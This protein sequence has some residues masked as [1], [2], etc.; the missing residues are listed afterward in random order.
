MRW[1]S[2]SLRTTLILGAAIAILLPALVVGY[3]QIG[4][5]FK[6]EVERRARTPTQQYAEVLS[7][8]LS[9]VMWNM[10]RDAITEQVDAVMRDPDVVSV[11]VSTQFGS[12]AVHRER[13][14]SS[15]A[16]TLREER[17]VSYLGEYCGHLVVTLSTDRIERELWREVKTLGWALA[18][19]VLVSFIFI[20]LLFEGRLVR[21]L[22]A[23]QRSAQ[24][25]ARGE[26]DTPLDWQRADEIGRLAQ[27][28]DR[29]RIDWAALIA[30]R[31]K[32]QSAL[33]ESN[34]N[35]SI[36]LQSI[37]DAVIA[38]DA[39]GLITRMNPTAERLTGWSLADAAGRPLTEVFCIIDAQTRL[40]LLNPVQRVM[41]IG[42]L[43]GLAKHTTLLSR[44]GAEFQIADSAAPILDGEGRVVG[45]VLVFSDVSEKY[46]VE[47]ALARTTQLLEYT[48]S[49]AKIG[50]WELNLKTMKI[51]WTREIFLIA[52]IDF[53]VEP[54]FE[55][56]INLFDLQARPTIT[57]ALQAAMD[58]GTP[59]DL[60]LP[61]IT[62][63]GRHIW[64]HTQAYAQMQDG[65]AVRLVGTFQDITERKLAQVQS[66]KNQAML[67]AV[68]DYA[69]ALISMKDLQGNITLANRKFADLDVPPVNE[70]IG[71]NVFDIFPN[72]VAQVLWQNDLAA[73][74][75]GCAVDSEETVHHADG[76]LHTYLTL[77]FPVKDAA[78]GVL[79]ICAI[80]SDI[81]E[82][83]RTDEALQASLKEKVALL[84][85]V[86]HRVKNNLQVI[87]SL[88]RLEAGR[89]EHAPTKAVLKD[90]Q[91]RIR[92]MALLHETI[93]RKGNFAA[94]D[95]GRY[96]GQIASQSVN[97]LQ[98]V[99]GTVQLRLDLGSVQVGLDQATPCGLLVS[100]L[101]SN[102]LKHG[103]PQ[104]RTGEIWIEL[105]PLSEPQLWRL[106]VRDT[107][108]G[109]P[110]DFEVR[111]K[112]SLG[113]QLAHDL[114]VQ[115]GGALDVG[116]GSEAV[117]T[118]DFR[119]ERPEPL[120]IN[121]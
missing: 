75:A 63:K 33:R 57:Q 94:I 28:L 74:E 80:S 98:T 109:L 65:K 11:T 3:F 114:A 10:D 5:P 48:G 7:R 91:G 47:E 38:T 112:N 32:A 71:R 90:M 50:G 73:L 43:A 100:E 93:Y 35:L 53:P 22:A 45:V 83:K 67:R 24:R 117:F 55:Q 68:L 18:A 119:V 110:E 17:N 9:V 54:T 26:L 84:N 37:G 29:M 99:P 120:V 70:L 101:V 108:V 76:T 58:T 121:L 46:R 79:G 49:L 25:L 20:W 6:S 19:Q 82:R 102:C 21:P 39:A 14:I 95:L 42:E 23:L 116:T 104:G 96:I 27:D 92:A 1:F 12:D 86:H 66:Q 30:A 105:T 16:A 64:V 111:Q 89:S 4:K 61:F 81:T 2:N 62:A 103:F 59:F 115:M 69:P 44:D 60:E 85:E 107:G 40:P 51:S 72:D 113:V 31:D 77:K 88:L 56:G 87:T 97:T 41:E 8:G 52:E 13:V 36:T 78:D 106:R 34:D 15:K 118:V